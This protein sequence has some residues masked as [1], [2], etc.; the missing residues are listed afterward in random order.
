MPPNRNCHSRQRVVGRAAIAVLFALCA[1]TGLTARA[2]AADPVWD[3]MTSGIMATLWDPAA[4]PGIPPL[5]MLQID[6]ERHRFSVH[7]F[8]D[9][10]MTAPM[11]INEW[12]HHT[13]GYVLFNA[14]LF[15]EDYSYLGLLLKDGRPLG[16]KRHHSWQG[17]FAAEPKDVS[18]RKAGVFDLAFDIFP[19]VHQHFPYREA[20][21]SLMLLD[22]T[23]KPRVR[24]TGKRAN[25]TIVAEDGE[26][27]ILI[28]KS[29]GPAPLYG[30]AECLRGA[31]PNIR[32][33]MAMDGGSSS[34]VIASPELL[35]AVPDPGRQQKWHAMLDGDA[36]HHIGLPAVIVVRPRITARSA[37]DRTASQT[38]PPDR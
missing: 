16:S 31:L 35:G 23:G 34:D 24:P 22:R 37:P 19:D 9:A 3:R 1:V 18:Q 14:G 7:Q 21:Q 29:V 33:A 15:R 27:K 10:G 30:L 8:R 13:G 28:M 4:C 6:P 38:P 32:Q 20:A 36:Q 2:S 17:L 11:T 5:L 25:Q 26:G 12:Q